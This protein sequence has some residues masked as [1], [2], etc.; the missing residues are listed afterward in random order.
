MLFAEWRE[1]PNALIKRISDL[2]TNDDVMTAERLLVAYCGI[3][4]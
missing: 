4:T 2:A 1:Q 3:R